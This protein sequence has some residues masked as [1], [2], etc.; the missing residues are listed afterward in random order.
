MRLG[1]GGCLAASI[2]VICVGAGLA[3]AGWVAAVALQRPAV[4]AEAPTVADS[5]AA[6]HKIYEIASHPPRGGGNPIV[7]NEREINALLSRQLADELPFSTTTARLIGDNQVEIVGAL[8]L[9]RLL[10]DVPSSGLVD[11]L[12]GRWSGRRVW[13]HLY[14][15]ARVE[16]V[17]GRHQLRLDIERF[18]AGRLPLPR[19][20]ARLLLDPDSLRWLRLRL[21]DHVQGVT[22]EPG[23]A[24]IR[25]AS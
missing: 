20:A 2:V 17:G 10:A 3:A 1:C 24:V 4:T 15:H 5:T 9:R 6:Q 7:L 12:P 16:T 13:L 21:P 19:I 23:R 11:R 22:I 14:V 25:F 8:P 18:A